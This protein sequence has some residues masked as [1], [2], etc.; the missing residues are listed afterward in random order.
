[1]DGVTATGDRHEPSVREQRRYLLA[2]PRRTERVVLAAHHERGHPDLGQPVLDPVVERE[3]HLPDQLDG[4]APEVVTDN[5]RSQA[6]RLVPAVDRKPE[7]VAGGAVGPRVDGRSYEYERLDELGPS[8]RKR[9]CDLATH[10]VR[11]EDRRSGKRLPQSPAEVRYRRRLT[12]LGTQDGSLQSLR[13]R[14]EIA[15]ADSE[16]VD[17]TEHRRTVAIR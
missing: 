11:D 3:A 13:Q 14:L 9:G 10:R 1:M 12:Q 17:E 2:P 8:G 5:R 7:E 4:M 16:P 6:R 15:L